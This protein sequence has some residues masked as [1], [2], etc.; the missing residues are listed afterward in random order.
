MMRLG[1]A[2]AERLMNSYIYDMNPS[3]RTAHTTHKLGVIF[4]EEIGPFLGFY[5]FNQVFC[6]QE[7]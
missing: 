4:T 6:T 1:L 3:I 2:L 5:E 7:E